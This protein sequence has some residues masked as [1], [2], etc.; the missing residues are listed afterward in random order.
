MILQWTCIENSYIGHIDGRL[1]MKKKI[2]II[3]CVVVA[4]L[5][6]IAF[7]IGDISS[8]RIIAKDIS[9]IY[10]QTS[11]DDEK[12][13]SVSSGNVTI[14]NERIALELSSET[15][16]FTVTE[17]TSGKAYYSVAQ[18]IEGFEPSAEQQSEVTI[19]YYDSNS[20]K[21]NMNSFENSIEGRSYEV[22]TNGS[23]IRVYYSIQKSKQLILHNLHCIP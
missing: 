9:K 10:T 21:I 13:K 11:E 4:I 1:D 16:H 19:T 12:W 20:A 5:L 17:K 8:L 3:S 15:A 18:A 22:K 2:T 14:E 23:A 7:I 6:C